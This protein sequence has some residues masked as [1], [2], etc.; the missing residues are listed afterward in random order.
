MRYKYEIRGGEM[1]VSRKKKSI[2]K[3]TVV[4]AFSKTKHIQAEQGFVGGP[5]AIGTFG[6][7]YLYPVFLRLGICT[8]TSAGEIG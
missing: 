1:F 4:M 6:A 5:K 8:A 3:A 7:S 2:T